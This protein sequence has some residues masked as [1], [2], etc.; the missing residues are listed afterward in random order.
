[1]EKITLTSGDATVSLHRFGAHIT[2]FKTHASVERLWLSTLADLSGQK[3]IRGG[4]PIAFPQFAD[5][6][7]LKLHGFARDSTWRVLEQ[8]PN[9]CKLELTQADVAAMPA[10]FLNDFC[11]TYDVALLSPT[12]LNLTLNVRN[13]SAAPFTFTGCLHT[14]FR[15]SDTADVLLSGLAGNQYTD[16]CGDRTIKTQSDDSHQLSIPA[17]SAK[18]GKEAER[19]GFVDRVYHNTGSDF[20]FSREGRALYRVSQT[21]SFQDTTLY[22]PW[23]GDKQ[24]P[25][26]PD[27]DDDGYTKTICLEPTLSDK[28]AVTLQAGESWE[29]GQSIVV[30][31]EEV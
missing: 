4:V 1:M 2:S 17:E 19:E 8:S 15:F 28:C 5:L 7:P 16:K 18:S 3:P 31:G 22:N 11:L 24:G 13:T 14:Y 30:C 10:E 26:G 21:E 9:S 25:V 27:F 6:G 23:L 29:G 20:E 12:E